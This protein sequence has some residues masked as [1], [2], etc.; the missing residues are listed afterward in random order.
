MKISQIIPQ[1]CIIT[2]LK[3]NSKSEIITELTKVLCDNYDLEAEISQEEA[4][5]AL[6]KR[7]KEQSTALGEGFA[8]PHARFNNIT[9]SYTVLAISKEGV[10]FDSLDGEL[11]HFFVMT[12]VPSSKANLLLKNRAALMR[13]LMPQEVRDI[14]LES[15]AKEI[16][17][18]LNE[19]SIEVD[20]DIIARDIM[21]PVVA[22]ISENSTINEAAR[23]LHKYHVDSL[24]VI[25]SEE[26][27]VKAVT[28]HDLFSVGLPAFF[29]NLK[30]ISF[31]KHMDPFE[32]YFQKEE[33]L[34]VKEIKARKE[35]PMIAPNATIIEVVFMIT[36]KKHNQLFVV[37]NGKILG[38]I[39]SFSIVDKIL[40]L[41]D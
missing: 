19:S 24:P 32:K 39:D 7:E 12:L 27:F 35:L 6:L 9:G 14:V 40:M 36:T 34:T 30:K 33:T 1:S 29:F 25:D 37:D 23:L 15:T 31:V 2:Q 22:T 28:C 5:E 10:D 20:N 4:I 17:Q 8:F 11:S 3:G 18:L 38:V 21:R 41:E 16:W 13:F 26:N